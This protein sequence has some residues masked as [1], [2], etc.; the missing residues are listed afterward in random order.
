MNIVEWAMNMVIVLTRAVDSSRLPRSVTVDTI[1][2]FK[3]QAEFWGG[4]RMMVFSSSK[5]LLLVL[6]TSLL[7]REACSSFQFYCH[8][9][10]EAGRVKKGNLSSFLF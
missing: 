1:S 4:L 8:R 3:K 6:L 2:N 10:E 9:L 5:T 7:L